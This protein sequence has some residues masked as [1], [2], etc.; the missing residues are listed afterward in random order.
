MSLSLLIQ[1]KQKQIDKSDFKIVVDE[2]SRFGK[3]NISEKTFGNTMMISAPIW[4][5]IATTFEDKNHYIVLAGY[6]TEYTGKEENSKALLFNNPCK[7]ISDEFLI[8][9]V[10]MIRHFKG[11]FSICI[12]QKSSQNVFVFNDHYGLYP[13]FIYDDDQTRILCNEYEP[14]IKLSQFNNQIDKQSVFEYFT[15][16]SIQGNR[17]FFKSITN[18]RPGH[19]IKITGE[20]LTVN[21]ISESNNPENFKGSPD[22]LSAEFYTIFKRSVQKRIALFNSSN[23]LISLT[24]GVDTRCITAEI[25][26]QYLKSLQFITMITPPLQ[27]ET[28]S[29][30]IIA[31][32]IAQ[33]M[34][35]NHEA[36]YFDYWNQDFDQ[37]FF[38]KLRSDT[39]EYRFTGH[40]GS[41]IY[42]AEFFYLIPEKVR[43]DFIK[44]MGYPFYPPKKQLQ[45]TRSQNLNS[46]AVFEGIFNTDFLKE[47]I[48]VE[49]II[50]EEYKHFN[51]TN[52]ELH[53]T[54]NLITRSFFTNFWDGTRGLNLCQPYMTS[55]KFC[56][57]FLDQDLISF[58]LQI[59]YAFLG[60]GKDKIYNGF[61]ERCCH[62]LLD[63]PTNSN[64]AN[65]E[66]AVLKYFPQ[67]VKSFD[68][69]N[70]K[71]AAAYKNYRSAKNLKSHEFFS[72]QFEKF[73][74]RTNDHK[75]P[76]IS[77]FIDFEA[78]KRYCS[79]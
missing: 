76:H 60:L 33:R 3:R 77:R 39:L 16:G 64:Y 54:I 78:W 25:P 17:T 57:P 5:Q 45:K 6:I 61:V 49:E 14:I 29:E 50:D 40:Y 21:K 79:I 2:F 18:L 74:K 23:P 37:T 72:T 46:Q 62:N 73:V 70:P 4:S 20:H 44:I 69:R 63:I 32:Q 13:V 58:I 34:E 15:A 10:E 11:I 43:Q 24:G 28:D 41:E 31:N 56:C 71:Y 22:D 19:F 66:G 65:H 59:P 53:F 67:K 35:L 38:D 52:K 42:K 8:S 48:P 47:I 26:E 9:G 12:F 27:P 51:N 68:M 1:D 55:Q 7:C 36:R 30:F 75:N